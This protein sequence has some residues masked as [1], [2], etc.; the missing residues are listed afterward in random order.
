MALLLCPSADINTTRAR[1]TSAAGSARER[2]KAC[3]SVRSVALNSISWLCGRPRFIG[4]PLAIGYTL[5]HPYLIMFLAGQYT[6]T[7]IRIINGLSFFI[8][9][10]PISFFIDFRLQKY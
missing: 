6:S 9:K 2:A 1:R 10:I 8:E 3:I 5:D 7:W 4:Y